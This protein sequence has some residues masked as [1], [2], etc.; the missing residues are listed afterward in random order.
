[1]DIPLNSVWFVP[2]GQNKLLSAYELHGAPL[3]AAQSFS[4]RLVCFMVSEDLEGL[5]GGGNDILVRSRAAVGARPMVSRVHYY[6]E[7]IPAG[8]VVGNLIS[9]TLCLVEDYSGSEA[10]RIELDMVEVDTDDTER[11]AALKSFAELAATMGAVFPALVPY[12]YPVGA[13][14]LLANQLLGALQSNTQ[15]LSA[16]L[17][18]YPG[19]PRIG[20][21]VL[22]QGVYVVFEQPQDV[23]NYTLGIDGQLKRLGKNAPVSYAVLEVGLDASQSP[24]FVQSQKLAT[25]LSQIDKD[26]QGAQDALA[27]LSGTVQAYSNYQKLLRYQELKAKTSRTADE[28]ALMAKIAAIDE[29]KPF[30][31]A[32]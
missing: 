28:D 21:M 19:P 8:K 16:P 9:D 7:D 27:F 2:Q 20:R 13:A 11:T 23:V 3:N 22:Q 17:V 15:V 14:A 30:L 18:L 24:E 1:M 31:P 10:L 29:L 25:L 26:R 6:D 4:V 32:P 5:L 12:A